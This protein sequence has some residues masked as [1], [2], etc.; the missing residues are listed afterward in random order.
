MKVSKSFSFDA[1]HQLVGH[2]GKCANLHGH[3]YK[4][5]VCISGQ[6]IQELESSQGMVYDFGDLKKI[7]NEH[8]LDKFDHATLLQGNEPIASL[9]ETKR[10]ILGFRSTAENMALFFAQQISIQLPAG[11][12]LEYVRLWETGSSFAETEKTDLLMKLDDAEVKYF[13]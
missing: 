13:G 5:E 2:A 4:L 6:I 8:V 11:I 10:V 9:L 12:E 7:V 3:T 1:S